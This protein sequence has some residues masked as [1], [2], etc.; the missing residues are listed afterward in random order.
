MGSQENYYYSNWDMLFFTARRILNANRKSNLWTVEPVRDGT[1]YG[2]FL[3]RLPQCFEVPIEQVGSLRCEAGKD[4][5]HG[6]PPSRRLVDGEI[7][8]LFSKRRIWLC[9]EKVTYGV[10]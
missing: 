5:T 7:Y 2:L 4:D 1:F 10:Q 8:N 3:R 6:G 9:Q